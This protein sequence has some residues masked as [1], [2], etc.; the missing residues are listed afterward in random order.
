MDY[1]KKAYN[2]ILMNIYR[3]VVN[4]HKRFLSN[5]GEELVKVTERLEEIMSELNSRPEHVQMKKEMIKLVYKENFKRIKQDEEFMKKYSSFVS[6]LP[7]SPSLDDMCCVFK[8]QAS[9][10][11][12]WSFS[13]V[14]LPEEVIAFYPLLF[15]LPGEEVRS[16][17]EAL[18]TRDFLPTLGLLAVIGLDLLRRM[19][20]ECDERNPLCKA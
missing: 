15:H 17:L 9:G 6:K 2:L 3:S 8:Q 13:F 14:P 5:K 4:S 12:E 11:L 19:G 16:A 20:V 1:V 18:S 10:L 7:D